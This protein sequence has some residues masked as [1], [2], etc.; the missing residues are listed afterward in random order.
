LITILARTGVTMSMRTRLIDHMITRS[1][2]IEYQKCCSCSF[3]RL[4]RLPIIDEKALKSAYVQGYVI[5]R[6][7]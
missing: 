1:M 5:R 3:P 7:R 2:H 6:T 4:G